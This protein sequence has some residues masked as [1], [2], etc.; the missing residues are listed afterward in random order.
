MGFVGV[1]LALLAF[2]VMVIIHELGHFTLAKLNGVKVEEF[3]V[4]MGPTIMAIKTKETVYSLKILPFGGSCMMLGEDENG[5]TDPRAFGNKSVWARMSVLF[6]GPF[7]NFLLAFVGAMIVI[8]AMG[9]DEPVLTGVMEGYP[10]QE[11]GMQAGDVITRLNNEPIHVY[12]DV[13]LYISMHQGED[14]VVKYERNGEKLSTTIH[15]KFSE[16]YNSYMMGIQVAG[17]RKQVGI[18]DNMK[19]SFYEVSYWI[20]YVFV[21]LKMLIT[22]EVSVSNVAGPVGMVSAMS[23][24]VEDSS[25]DGVFYVF[26]NLVNV[27]VLLSANLGVMNL[28]PLPALDGGRLLFC[29]LEV[30]RGKPVNPKYEAYV[31]AAGLILLLT[32]SV[33]IMFKDIW[34]LIL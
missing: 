24:M 12:R 18:L 19:Y 28:L 2:S 11:A 30:L 21:S 13:S 23:D 32:L 14:L 33:V 31:H 29:F 26:I 6:A 16:E 17:A 22:K 10:A 4:G 3:S 7:N 15:P 20:R 5:N 9:I 8:G 27:I 1:I 25:K 34:Q